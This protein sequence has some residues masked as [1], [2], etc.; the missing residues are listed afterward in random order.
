ML[1]SSREKT[2]AEAVGFDYGDDL[3]WSHDSRYLYSNRPIGNKPEIFRIPVAG[4]NPEGI[5]DLESFS[6][7]TGKFDNGLCIAPDE[8]VSGLHQDADGYAS[9]FVAAHSVLRFLH[10][11]SPFHWFC[12]LW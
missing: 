1:V 11:N 10:D 3:S 2:L 7:L 6:R 8:S 5:V 4:G 9:I 12:S